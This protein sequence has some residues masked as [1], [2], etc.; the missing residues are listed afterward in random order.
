M[1][2]SDTEIVLVKEEL[3][4]P[5]VDFKVDNVLNAVEK[6]K[7]AGGKVLV[8]PFEIPIGNCSVVQDPWNNK[9]VLLD[10]SKGLLKVDQ[11]KNVIK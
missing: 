9:F 7:E 1:K 3:E 11:N 5:E 10:S 4:Y 6:F 8:E 2:D